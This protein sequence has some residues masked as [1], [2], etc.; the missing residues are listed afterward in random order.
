[1]INEGRGAIGKTTNA[2][3]RK[4]SFK[5]IF[6]NNGPRTNACGITYIRFIK[7]LTTNA[8]GIT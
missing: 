7:D 1:M 8:C 5:Y 2:T 3:F 4:K 6:H